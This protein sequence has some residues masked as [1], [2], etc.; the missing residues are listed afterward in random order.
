MEIQN[1]IDFSGDHFNPVKYWILREVKSRVVM[2]ELIV[3][4]NFFKL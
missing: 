4:N 1:N 2:L 3:R